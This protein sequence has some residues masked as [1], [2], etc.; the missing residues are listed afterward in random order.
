VL[1][2][3]YQGWQTPTAAPTLGGVGGTPRRYFAGVTKQFRLAHVEWH[4]TKQQPIRRPAISID[5]IMCNGRAPASSS[6]Y[7]AHRELLPCRVQ[8]TCL[9][10]RR[11]LWHVVIRSPYEFPV[12]GHPNSNLMV[13]YAGIWNSSS[14][15]RST[16]KPIALITCS[17]LYAQGVH[18][19]L[20]SYSTVVMLATTSSPPP[21]PPCRSAG[22]ILPSFPGPGRHSMMLR[23]VLWSRIGSLWNAG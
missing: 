9:E 4:T 18:M 3:S 5:R 2:E 16:L 15:T 23:L 20:T 1:R 13:S 14:T 19:R 7:R 17:T 12:E 6:G 22:T 21:P 11:S 10:D 8:T